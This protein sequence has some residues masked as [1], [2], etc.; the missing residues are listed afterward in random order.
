MQ[1]TM[2]HNIVPLL[3]GACW[4]ANCVAQEPARRAAREFDAGRSEVYKTIGDVRLKMFIVQPEG[5]KPTDRRA[6][7]VFFFGGGWRGGSPAQFAEH[8][9]YL[10]SR[11]MVAM[12]ADYRV[13]SRH[14]TLADSCVHDAKS[15]IRWVR[16][17]A[18]R[19]GI[20]PDRI[21]AAG[22]SAGG[23]LA[24]CTGVIRDFD[25]P[26]EDT[27]I[28]S[29]PNAMALFNPALVLAPVGDYGKDSR[30]LAGMGE[31]MG[32]EPKKLSPYHHVRGGLPPTVVFHG[33]DDRTVALVTAEMFRDAMQDAGNSCQLHAYPGQGHGF[34]NY[35]R[36][37]GAMYRATLRSLDE[38]LID[39][40]YLQ[41]S[42]TVA[43]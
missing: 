18:D 9:K 13:R 19:L 31:R 43:Q 20:D 3:L 25:E 32:V 7:I 41:G 4:I 33:T 21:V 39:L 29:A 16:A 1:R 37:G 24:A 12:S 6:A 36:D 2:R 28:S 5:H 22:G 23:H 27:S 17:N 34:F 35:N 26:G 14:G 42:P 10:A 30:R 40:G 8:C 15:A 11:G 38:F